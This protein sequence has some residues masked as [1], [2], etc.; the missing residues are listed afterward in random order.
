MAARGPIPSVPALALAALVG[1]APA[2]AQ[3]A[4]DLGTEEQRAA[5][6]EVYDKYCG[7]CHGPEGAGD[8]IAAPRLHPAPRDLTSGKYKIRSTPT[9]YLPTDADIRRSIR[10]G[11]PYTG[12]PGFPELSNRQV[13]NLVYYLK[14]LASDFEDPSA[15]AEPLEIPEPPPFSEDSLEVGFETYVQIGC[16]RCHG[17][18]GRGD[19]R[20]APTM[21]DDWGDFVRPADLT[22]PW[23]FRGGGS[24]ED[25]FR[26]ISTGLAG[27]PMAGFA[28][29]LT[30][31]QRWQIVDWIVAQAGGETEAPYTEVVRAVG[32]EDLGALGESTPIEEAREL[33]EGAPAA[34][35]PV[36]GQ[37]IEPGR[38]FNP[39]VVA[40]E[41]RALYDPDEIAF[42]VTW[43]D[44]RADTSGE[45]GPAIEVP[46]FEEQ[47]DPFAPGSGGAGSEPPEEEGE[48]AGG[49]DDFW[50]TGAAPAPEEEPA[51]QTG[52]GFWGESAGPETP[53]APTVHE[54]PWS[55]AVAIQLPV[56]L[57]EGVAKPYFLFGSPQYPVE[58][59]F[60][61][62]AAGGGT[63]YEARGG[64]SV[65]PGEGPAPTVASG[66][67]QGR[68]AV[69]MKR[70]R[71]P[72]RGV[73]FAEGSFVPIAFH[74][75]DGFWHERGS[76]RGLT[77]WYDV[78][79]VPAETPEVLAPMAKAAAAVLGVEL[80]VIGLV[81][82][83]YR[84]DSEAV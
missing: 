72:S 57:R 14:S 21:R 70:E 47:V 16:A 31:E 4:V 33:F 60:T 2:A 24:R 19:G 43:N 40:V 80:L 53:A 20:S 27:S 11:L 62:L 61:D 7:Q 50:G 52:G 66:Y 1:A 76:R 10:Q 49:A 23:T 35:F 78:Y 37:I 32:V 79:L 30:E 48:D 28:D 58:L 82:R 17:E 8:G 46:R 44:V 42:L 68:W 29:G 12:M 34:M 38:Q 39:S 77:S 45:N 73:Q 18:Q 9:G 22:M 67:H 69:V 5:G 84:G 81:R 13:T 74:V 41:V 75:W 26:S 51:E 6:R 59:W 54:S 55:D 25:I 56:E 63:L 71:F 64:G 36:V 83:K 65:A 15:Y 3:P